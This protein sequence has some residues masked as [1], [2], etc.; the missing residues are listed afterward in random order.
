MCVNFPASQNNQ[1]LPAFTLVPDL[2]TNGASFLFHFVSLFDSS[3]EEGRES[4]ERESDVQQMVRP[5]GSR[6][7]LS[8]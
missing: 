7:F 6:E 8:F 4:R 3:S 1:V 5:V 2:T